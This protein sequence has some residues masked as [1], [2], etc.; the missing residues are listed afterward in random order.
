MFRNGSLK[1]SEPIVIAAVTENTEKSSLSNRREFIN[2]IEEMLRQD[3][4]NPVIR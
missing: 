3:A 2:H 4:T 1:K